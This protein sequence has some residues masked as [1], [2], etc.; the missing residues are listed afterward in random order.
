M[1]MTRPLAILATCT[2]AF[3]APLHAD[4]IP[5]EMSCSGISPDWSLS[6]SGDEAEFSFQ[7]DSDLNVQLITTPLNADW[8]RAITMIGRGDSAILI[9]EPARCDTGDMSARVLTQRGETPILLVGC[10]QATLD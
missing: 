10:C 7:R 8:P 5:T 2:V 4:D 1:L 9:V 6:L 3:A